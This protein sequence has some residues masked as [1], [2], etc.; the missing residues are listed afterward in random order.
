[1][2][3]TQKRIS[4]DGDA[5]QEQDIVA[6]EAPDVSASVASLDAAIK[7]AAKEKKNAARRAKRQQQKEREERR[8][9]CGLCC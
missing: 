9:C 4:G 6:V 8:R 3:Q 1:M 7:E 2:P 5:P